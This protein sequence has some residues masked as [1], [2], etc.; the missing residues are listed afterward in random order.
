MAT[1]GGGESL[2]HISSSSVGILLVW[3]QITDVVPQPQDGQVLGI[4]LTTR[5]AWG[6]A[7]IAKTIWACSSLL[8]LRWDRQTG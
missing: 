4:V 2:R 1:Y 7:R 3:H 8:D 6:S 5:A